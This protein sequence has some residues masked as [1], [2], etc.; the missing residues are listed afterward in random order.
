MRVKNHMYLSEIRMQPDNPDGNGF[1]HERDKA[2]DELVRLHDLFHPVNDDD[3][4]YSL[5][6]GIENGQLALQIKNAHGRDLPALLLSLTPYRRLIQDYFLMIESY[7]RCRH[8]G[9]RDKL[10]TID[11]AR[12]GLHNEGAELLI[13]RLKGKIAIEPKLVIR[14]TA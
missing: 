10:Q 13:A 4:P 7:N 2:M 8:E 6:I 14:D 3:G 5:T 9:N 12:R 11:M 1:N